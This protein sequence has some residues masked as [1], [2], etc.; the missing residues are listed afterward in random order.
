M[1]DFD[2]EYSAD[3]ALALERT[4]EAGAHI[5]NIKEAYGVTSQ[6]GLPGLKLAIESEGNV[7]QTTFY[8][9]TRDGSKSLGAQQV[10]ALQ[11]ILGLRGLK[12]VQGQV[13]GWFNGEK[14]LGTAPVYPDLVGKTIGFVVQRELHNRGTV[15]PGQSH[16][17]AYNIVRFFHPTSRL[18]SSEILGGVREP[19][20]L[21]KFLDRLTDKDARTHADVTVGDVEV[22]F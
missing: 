12:S 5:G 9:K 1:S 10:S 6:N 8:L 19:K 4:K 22:P 20:A 11:A 3:D 13:E 15:R 7:Y 2:I 17:V 16:N 18:T 21:D 14:R